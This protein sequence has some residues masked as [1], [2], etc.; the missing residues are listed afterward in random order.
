MISEL[1]L[2]TEYMPLA[3]NAF[4]KVANINYLETTP[5]DQHCMQE[6]IKRRG[7]SGNAYNY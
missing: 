2:E 1:K 3:N 7:N 6:D 5:T 4:V